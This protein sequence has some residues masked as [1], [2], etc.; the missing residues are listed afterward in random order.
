MKT[1][2]PAWYASLFY[3]FTGKQCVVY[4]SVTEES[5]ESFDKWIDNACEKFGHSTYNLVGAPSSIGEYKGPTLVE[6][7]EHMKGKVRA[8]FGC[9]C[10]PERHTKKGNESV[11]MV[12]KVESGA[13]WFITQGIYSSSA[14]I[15]CA[16]TAN[17]LDL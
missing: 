5:L 3:E 7:M 9:V 13:D 15:R 8:S 17:S 2:D 16:R 12:R 10:I 4:K 11:N 14:V 1:L 6:A